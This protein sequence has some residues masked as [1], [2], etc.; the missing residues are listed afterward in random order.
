MLLS[1][2]TAPTEE[3]IRVTDNKLR[4]WLYCL[5]SKVRVCVGSTTSRVKE[6]SNPQTCK[7]GW[8]LGT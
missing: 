3:V 2:F 1:P 8:N 5:L 6:G 7:K 4:P